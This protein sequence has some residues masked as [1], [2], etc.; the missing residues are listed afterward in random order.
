MTPTAAPGSGLTSLFS[1]YR[2]LVPRLPLRIEKVRPALLLASCVVG[3]EVDE[4][5]LDPT[6]TVGLFG[7]R[8]LREQRVDVLLDCAFGEPERGRDPGVVPALRH[9]GEH[10]ALSGREV[11]ER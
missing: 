5:R 2:T 7:Q 8:E 11:L 9:L 4:H 6:V 3:R 1:A 10:L